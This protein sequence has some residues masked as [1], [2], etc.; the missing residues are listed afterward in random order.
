MF[1]LSFSANTAW[2]MYNFRAPVLSHFICK[3]Y[4]VS[5]IVPYDEVYSK[6]LEELGCR[7]YSIVL[8]SKGT[9]PF[10]DIGL[11]LQYRRL[12]REIKPDMSITYTIKPNIYGSMAANSL[13]IP[14]LP[15][16]TGLGYVFLS[17]NV[18][19]LV[20]KVLYRIAFSQAKK[21]WFLNRDDVQTFL[22]QHLID[23]SKVE[24][25]PGEGI[26]LDRFQQK[27]LPGKEHGIRFLFVGRMLTDK[28]VQEYVEAA[29][30]LKN[31]Y[32]DVV[33]Q[34]LGAIW[35]ENPA[36]VRKEQI[37]EWIAEGVV[38][39]LGTTTDVRPFLEQAHCIVLPSYREGIPCTLMEGA[40]IG[41][42]LVATDVPG[43]HEVVIDG[44]NGF[45]CKV[46]NSAS[47]AN[48]L[49]KVLKLSISELQEMG[50]KGR[51]WM[52]EKFDINYILKQYDKVVE[53]IVTK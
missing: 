28:G 51:K 49:E 44:Q 43:C 22:E 2:G 42:P 47:L 27:T 25:L 34:L 53:E 10:K 15:I 35:E 18:V 50:N 52:E 29:R 3:G 1:H 26:N 48:A 30:F 14:Y 32:P 38:D 41:R 8:N 13:H 36:A 5:V 39:Y 40:A 11:L 12:F 46:R 31:K 20:A 37:D 4:R 9:N 23:A 24:Q 16:T 45:L 19:S 21:V 33:F 17:Q 7:V 6:C